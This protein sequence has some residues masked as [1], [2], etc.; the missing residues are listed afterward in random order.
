M[1]ILAA[2][3]GISGLSEDQKC[4]GSST[5]LIS[6]LIFVVLEKDIAHIKKNQESHSLTAR[7]AANTVP[8][9]H[10]RDHGNDKGCPIE[11]SATSGGLLSF[12]QP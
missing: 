9:H 6:E 5:I 11:T 2:D 8:G 4:L 1:R 12:P 10:L 3:L 7:C